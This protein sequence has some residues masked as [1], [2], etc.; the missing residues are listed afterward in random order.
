[1]G[2]MGL[3]TSGRQIL[4]K[5]NLCDIFN[6]IFHKYIVL[7][8]HPVC[9]VQYQPGMELEAKCYS[10]LPYCLLLISHRSV[11]CKEGI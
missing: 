10:G 6:W 7:S 5:V 3:I 4:G 11:F 9:V 8:L 1:M 2:V